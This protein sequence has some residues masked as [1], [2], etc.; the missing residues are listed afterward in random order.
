MFDIQK[1]SVRVPIGA[2]HYRHRVIV[3]CQ[4]TGP[5]DGLESRKALAYLAEL[6]A[7]QPELWLCAGRTPDTFL[8][9]FE[10]GSWRVIAEAQILEGD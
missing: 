10:E 8:F 9:V 1:T 7:T 4:Q 5:K 2:G 6:L 3:Q